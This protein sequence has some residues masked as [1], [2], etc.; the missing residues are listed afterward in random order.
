MA[1]RVRS[2]HEAPAVSTREFVRLEWRFLLFGL[3][4]ALWSSPGQTFLISLFGGEI[5]AAFSLSHG[6]FGALY[7][8]ATLLSAALLLP[9]GRLIDR[10]PLA[11]FTRW[12]VLGLIAATAGFTLVAGPVSLVLGIFALRFTGQGLMSHI[13]LTAMARRYRQERGRALAAASLGF[14]IGEGLF[15]LGVVWA[16]TLA[17]WR[18][19]WVA[20]AAGAGLLLLP[21]L[22]PLLRRTEHQDG[23]GAA[24]LAPA[25]S[26]ERHWTRGELLR[27]PRFY[28]LIPLPIAQSAIITGIL[29]HQVHLVALKGW[30]LEWWG[31]SFLLYA[32][33]SVLANL[34]SGLLIDRFSARALIPFVLVPAV[35]SLLALGSL[36]SPWAAPLV[37]GLMG[38]SAG[39]HG[40]AISALWAELYGTRHLGAI[41]ALATALSVFASALGPAAMGLPLDAGASI[42]A[43]AF[44]SLAIMVLA[45]LS[46]AWALIKMV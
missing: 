16:L 1:N 11:V 5:R 34:A 28:F 44:W 40:T 18:W 31:S 32:L 4:V 15:P 21:L 27:D 2:G 37:L 42:E 38:A 33:G 25:P 19:I 41:R 22:P 24:A 14:P 23:A 46:A 43:I 20:L 17:D 29:F 45:S 10:L 3:L 39:A 36:S 13:A 12:V 8:L 30:S 7:M 9:A 26:D 6:E 35:L